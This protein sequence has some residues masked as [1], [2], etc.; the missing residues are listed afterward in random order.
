EAAALRRGGGLTIYKPRALRPCAR[1][2]VYLR[3]HGTL[4][5]DGPKKRD[6]KKGPSKPSRRSSHEDNPFQS[7]P[8]L[9]RR[10][11]RASIFQLTH[12]C[13]RPPAGFVSDQSQK[14]KR[15]ESEGTVV[16]IE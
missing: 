15:F 2:N 8:F 6:E 11:R 5:F 1:A 16:E 3:A 14:R 4:F 12:L 7:H 9:F 13:P 10:T